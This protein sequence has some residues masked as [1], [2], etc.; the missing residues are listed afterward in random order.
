[1]EERQCGQRTATVELRIVLALVTIPCNLVEVNPVVMSQFVRLGIIVRV[2]AI[3]Q[4]L[5]LVLVLLSIHGNNVLSVSVNALRSVRTHEERRTHK[6]VI[7][8]L[9]AHIL[10]LGIVVAHSDCERHLCVL[11]YLH[12]SLPSLTCG[13]VS[14]DVASKNGD[15]GLLLLQDRQNGVTRG[16]ASGRFRVPMDVRKLHH[17][18]LSVLEFEL[19]LGKSRSHN[20]QQEQSKQ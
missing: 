7:D 18:E 4:R 11:E 16:V 14:N 2:D 15:V 9:L 10:R 12:Y 13:I 20:Q 19:A 8:V 5:S 17:L 1:M 3:E 6:E